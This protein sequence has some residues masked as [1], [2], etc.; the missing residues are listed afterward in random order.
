MGTEGL[1]WF[2][3]LPDRAARHALLDCCSAPGWA[4]QMTAA[5]PF[6]SAQDAI[7]QSGAIVAALTVQDLAAALAGHPRIGER[8]DA[9]GGIPSVAP[10]YRAGSSNEAPMPPQAAD[11]SAQEQSGVDAEDTETRQAL[12]A[13]NERY[14]Q[15]F[16]HI[17]LVCAAGRTGSELL[18]VLHD[19]LQNEPDDEWQVVRAELQ[20]INALRLQRLMTG[21]P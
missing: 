12:A 4:A 21:M 17:Y 3:E 10:R 18:T 6:A 20:K 7:R 8:P 1:T 14:E 16:G 9:C 2:N 5:R 19:R 15:R 13:A 11:W